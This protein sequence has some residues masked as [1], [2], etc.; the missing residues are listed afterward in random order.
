MKARTVV[1]EAPDGG[2]PWIEYR[3]AGQRSSFVRWHEG[4]VLRYR[5]FAQ[6]LDKES[7]AEALHAAFQAATPR[8]TR[9]AEMVYGGVGGALVNAPPDLVEEVLA[10]VVRHYDEA[11]GR[12]A[13]LLA[14]GERATV[15]VSGGTWSAA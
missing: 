11:L 1:R 10:I 2:A 13:R 6:C 14:M 4:S 15:P 8:L 12:L 7:L 9:R 3:L 5:E